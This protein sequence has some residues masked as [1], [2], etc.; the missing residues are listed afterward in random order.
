MKRILIIL[1]CFMLSACHSAKDLKSDLDVSL[2]HLEKTQYKTSVSHRKP[3][4][5]YY[6]QK[7]V[8]SV[9]SYQFGSLLK[10]QDAYFVMNLN[11]QS[12]I[13]EKFYKNTLVEQQVDHK[14]RLYQR[15]SEYVDYN[16]KSN[17]Y[18][19]EVY[20]MDGEYFIYLTTALFEFYAQVSSVDVEPIS[21]QMLKIAKTVKVDKEKVIS[22]YSNKESIE[23][24]KQQVKLFEVAIPESG[25]LDE[26]VKGN[27][28][29][30]EGEE[31]PS[32]D[33]FGNDGDY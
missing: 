29:V 12:I 3:L 14:K 24:V 5:S 20:D 1:L 13:N 23:Y 18:K 16:G 25:R 7:G 32:V 2:Q 8:G 27:K 26:M 10:Y 21:Y 17:A 30:Q 22:L 11:A 31:E 33:D 19:L 28:Q 15:E 9:D 6:L 4:Y